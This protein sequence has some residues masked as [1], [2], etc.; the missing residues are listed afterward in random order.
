MPML[1]N[2]MDG[3]ASYLSD[4]ECVC[5]KYCAYARECFAE[6]KNPYIAL[7]ELHRYCDNCIFS[8]MEED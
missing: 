8:S 6:N 7:M 1:Y 2:D 5:I 4:D 3:I